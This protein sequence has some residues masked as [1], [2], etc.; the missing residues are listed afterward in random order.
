MTPDT[1]FALDPETAHRLA[2][3]Y[4]TPL[5]V[6]GEAHF[7]GTI[8]R[9]RS[10]LESCW[11]KTALSYASK[12]N[13]TLALLQ[14]AHQ[15][16]CGID[17][18]GSGELVGALTAGI[19]ARN[20]HLHGNAKSE[21]ELRLALGA[22]VGQVV[23]DSLDE[24][25]LLGRL[26]RGETRF[27]IRLNPAVE[28]GTHEKISTAH[29]ASKF[30]LSPDQAALALE[31][32][33]ALGIAV[34]GVHMHVGSMV[35]S[36]DALRAAADA[37]AR[38]AKRLGDDLA[39]VNFGGGIAVRQTVAE[40]PIVLE[41]LLREILAPAYEHLPPHVTVKMEPGRA[42]I[43]ESGVT[44]YSVLSR[45]QAGETR[46]V[47]VD[48]GLSDNP[49]PTLYGR[50]FDVENLSR[51]GATQRVTVA[52]AHCESDNLFPHVSLP[53]DTQPGDLLQVRCTGA[54][55]ASMASQYNRFRR[56]AVVLIRTNDEPFVAVERDD[57]HRSL[58]R[59]RCLTD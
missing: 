51:D 55:N 3:T 4:G 12:A 15:E 37:L 45:K 14:I 36:G 50:A 40:A 8:Q 17:C 2:A 57:W 16:S 56:P 44:L 22:G 52:G 20:I 48:G 34:E 18:A 39:V 42:L 27:L 26:E 38:F 31:Q 28:S 54:Y 41:P 59:E 24:I 1:R 13:G 21:E 19:P 29:R 10:A 30:G 32:C 53:M 23:I 35:R 25:A 49:S 5:Y 46:Y 9:F 33:R 47:S 7:R 11:P 6:V 43:G 58:A